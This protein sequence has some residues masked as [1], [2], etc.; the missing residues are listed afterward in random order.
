MET[1]GEI[2]I[3]FVKERVVFTLLIHLQLKPFVK[4]DLFTIHKDFCSIAT[5]YLFSITL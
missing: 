3:K 2:D 1:D 4:V 5:I